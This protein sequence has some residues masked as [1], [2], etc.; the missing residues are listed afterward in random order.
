MQPQQHDET[1][2]INFSSNIEASAATA[3][4]P[5]AKAMSAVAVT[6][7]NMRSMAFTMGAT[8]QVAKNAMPA[9][10]ASNEAQGLVG[11]RRGSPTP[12]TGG[13]TSLRP[14]PIIDPS[15]KVAVLRMNLFVLVRILFQYLERVDAEILVLA[16]A[17]LKDCERKQKTNNSKYPTLADAINERLRDAVGETHWTQARKIQKQLVINQ[18]LK[19][20]KALKAKTACYARG[21]TS[22]PTETATATRRFSK[23]VSRNDEETEGGGTGGGGVQQMQEDVIPPYRTQ[24]QVQDTGNQQQSY[25]NSNQDD[26]NSYQRQLNRQDNE[27]SEM[28][29]SSGYQRFPSQVTQHIDSTHSIASATSDRTSVTYASSANGGDERSSPQEDKKRRFN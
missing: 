10:S 26:T 2:S 12:S 17:V 23:G 5:N 4:T 9:M 19:K 1:K 25:H 20:L 28:Q 11:S 16:K 6:M 13:G 15:Q 14:G 3:S 7:V 27:R 22:Q 21:N 24:Q 18:Q 8:K 29:P